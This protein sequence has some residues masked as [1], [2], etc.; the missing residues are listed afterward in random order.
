MGTFMS[1]LRNAR[2]ESYGWLE[3]SLMARGRRLETATA[4]FGSEMDTPEEVR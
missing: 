2:K 1:L 3:Y 4:G